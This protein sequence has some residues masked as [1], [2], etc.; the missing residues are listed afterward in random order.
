MKIYLYKIML[1][2]HGQK[3]II[4]HFITDGGGISM[5]G[6]YNGFRGQNKQPGTDGV[7]ELII[8]SS[9]QVG[10]AD[11]P[12]EK[13]IPGNDKSCPLWNNMPGFRVNVPEQGL[14]ARIDSPPG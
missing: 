9:R 13:G 2:S 3:W 6:I 11:T 4:G 8:V 10:S 7:N 5:T 14:P 12:L 1:L